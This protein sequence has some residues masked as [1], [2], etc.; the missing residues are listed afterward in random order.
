MKLRTKGW[1]E[2]GVFCAIFGALIEIHQ[3]YHALDHWMA[4]IWLSFLVVSGVYV[5]IRNYSG[6]PQRSIPFLNAFPRSWQR[7]FLGE[8]DDGRG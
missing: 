7:W 8:S 2:F 3:H 1:L 5:L 6:K 4:L